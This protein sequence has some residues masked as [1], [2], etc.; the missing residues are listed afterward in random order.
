MMAFQQPF[1]DWTTVGC[2]GDEG[3]N[4]GENPKH[5]RDPGAV[6][7]LRPPRCLG[8][9]AMTWGEAWD[10]CCFGAVSVSK[11]YQNQ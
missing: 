4:V 10:G 2:S 9:N 5:A 3:S 7:N 8:A 6:V 11:S 1:Q